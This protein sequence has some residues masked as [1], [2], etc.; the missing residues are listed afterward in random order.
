VIH[1]VGPIWS[2]GNR[3]EREL[4]ASAYDSVFA[5]ARTLSDLRS[6]AFVSSRVSSTKRASA[7]TAS[8]EYRGEIVMKILSKHTLAIVA[9]ATTMLAFCAT[10]SE[11]QD[12]VR[13]TPNGG[14]TTFA[15]RDPLLR[16]KP[17]TVL[18]SKTNQGD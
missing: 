6:I 14:F 10:P 13:F 18:V 1:T 9:A 5:L 16:I 2:G 7:C 4:L 15:K 8:F 12:T 17:K 3:R 11:A